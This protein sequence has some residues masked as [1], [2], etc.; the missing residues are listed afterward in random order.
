MTRSRN[1]DPCRWVWRLVGTVMIAQVAQ[2]PAYAQQ[3]FES[4]EQA[5]QSLADAASSGDIKKIV[6]VL[7]PAGRDIISSGDPV[8]DRS[9]R[10]QFLAYYGVSHKIEFN[11]PAKATLIIG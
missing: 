7:G 10:E 9:T 2:L 5:A 3:R 4:P 8:A 6:A 11:N 1:L